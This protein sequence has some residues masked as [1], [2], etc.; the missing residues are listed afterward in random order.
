MIISN[1]LNITYSAVMPDGQKFF[2]SIESNIVETEI[3]SYSVSKIINCDKNAC[4]QGEKFCSTITITNNS[5]TKLYN[6]FFSVPQPNG[7]NFVEGS[8]KINGVA[9]PDYDPIKGFVLPDLAPNELVIIE[10]ELK[11]NKPITT[12][13]ITHFGEIQ[14]NVKD[15][16]RGDINYTEQTDNIALDIVENEIKVVKSVNK[17]FAVKGENLHYTINI[18]NTDSIAKTNVIF[19]DSIPNGTAFISNSVKINGVGY[20]VYNP[21]VGFIIQ[22]LEPNEV[23]IIEFDVKVT[24]LKTIANFASVTYDSGTSQITTYSNVTQTTINMPN[25][26]NTDYYIIVCDCD[27]CINCCNCCQCCHYYNCCCNMKY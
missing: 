2:A 23:L 16:V 27:C 6:N 22:S 19:K 10:Y 3:L 12:N 9:Y 20:S 26:D 4:R 18:T 8:V 17:E 7:A 24:E 21:N 15:P 13:T 14:Y 5:Q 1:K 25:N 11:A